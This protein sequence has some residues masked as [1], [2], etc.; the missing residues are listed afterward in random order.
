MKW[1]ARW[2]MAFAFASSWL[3]ACAAAPELDREAERAEIARVIDASIG[4]AMTK[5]TVVLFN[6]MARDSSFFIYHPD[7]RSTIIGFEAFHRLP[8]RVWLTDDFKATEYSIRDLRINISN[9]GDVAWYSALLDDHGE[10][11]GQPVG[12]DDCRWTGVLEKRNGRWVI[13]QMHFS[14]ASDASE[15]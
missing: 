8:E 5:D 12:W 2:V 13:V 4:W 1:N 9:S 15:S 10:W 11:Q 6:S 14:L 7:S 3:A